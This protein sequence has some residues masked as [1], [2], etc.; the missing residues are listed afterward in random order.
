MIFCSSEGILNLEKEGKLKIE[1]KEKMCHELS[2]TSIRCI[3][4]EM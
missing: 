4:R 2:S 1:V 3:I